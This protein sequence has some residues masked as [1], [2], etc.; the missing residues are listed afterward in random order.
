[1][2]HGVNF[3]GSNKTYGPPP[4]VPEDQCASLHVFTNGKC[5]VSCH[6][7]TPEELEEINRTGKVWQ[8]VWSG[9]TLFPVFIGSETTVRSVVVDYGPVWKQE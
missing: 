7:L 9:Q 2:A 4:G 6:Q 8:S 3:K 5:I 1:M